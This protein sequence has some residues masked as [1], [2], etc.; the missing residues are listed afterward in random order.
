VVV[1]QHDRVNLSRIGTVVVAS[2]TS[3]LRY[4]L[5]PGNVRLAKGE[6]GLP[7]SSVVNVTQI[8]TIDRDDIE[9]KLRRLTPARLGEVWQGVRLMLEPPPYAP[10]R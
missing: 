9:S 2:I 6:A 1:L 10:A 3:R 5:L 7:R 4:A 8:S